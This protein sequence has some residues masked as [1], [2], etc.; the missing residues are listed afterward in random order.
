MILLFTMP[1]AILLF[2]LLY[3]LISINDNIAMLIQTKN[4]VIQVISQD[5][6]IMC[7]R[8]INNSVDLN[9][10][11]ESDMTIQINI[12]KLFKINTFSNQETAQ[13]LNVWMTN[14][15]SQ[16]IFELCNDIKHSYFYFDID[17]YNTPLLMM[18][19]LTFDISFELKYADLIHLIKYTCLSKT[20]TLKVVGVNKYL[21]FLFDS[22]IF[23]GIL[24][25]K[26]RC[27]N[28]KNMS[29]YN[30][31]MQF[32]TRYWKM[33]YQLL[34]HKNTSIYFS[35]SIG[36]TMPIKLSFC[37]THYINDI[38]LLPISLYN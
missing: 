7:N 19:H 6:H 29:Q 16:I 11:F 38:F 34:N 26:N 14:D 23:N 1:T 28:D 35:I 18:D 36:D 25:F 2:E 13:S 17:D 30:C 22:N 15:K 3:G 9:I 20:I 12:K 8:F 32:E 10:V 31:E 4:I 33:M 21:M 5:Q 37:T 27:S 24:Y